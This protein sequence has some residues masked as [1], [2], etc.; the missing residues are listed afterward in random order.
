MQ[1]VTIAFVAVYGVLAFILSK[2]SQ[3]L[4][5]DKFATME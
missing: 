5:K 2:V 4:I 3:T 1:L